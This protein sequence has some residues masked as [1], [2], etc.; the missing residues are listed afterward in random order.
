MPLGLHPKARDALLPYIRNFID[1]AKVLHGTALS[2]SGS[3][4]ELLNAETKLPQSGPIR[5]ALSRYVS[6]HSVLDFIPEAIQT[7]L[8]QL[9]YTEERNELPLIAALEIADVEV[10][11][12]QLLEEFESLPWPYWATINLPRSLADFIT[13]LDQIHELSPQVRLIHDQAEIGKTAA[14]DMSASNSLLTGLGG[15]FG[16]T[17]KY[18]EERKALQLKVKG[19]VP[20]YGGSGTVDDTRSLMRSF[21]GIGVALEIF[22][23]SYSPALPPS[24]QQITFRRFDHEEGI[25][26]SHSLSDAETS[27]IY[28]L[29]VPADF[30]TGSGEVAAIARERLGSVS[31]ILQNPDKHS[32]LLRACEWL[33]NSH[34]GDDPLLSFV[35]AMVVLE[36]LLGNKA[37]SKE[38]GLGTLLANRC[39]YMIGTTTSEREM[40]LRDFAAIYDV[41]SQIVHSGKHRLSRREMEQ[42]QRLRWLGRRVIQEE[43]KLAVAEITRNEAV[44]RSAVVKALMDRSGLP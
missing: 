27:A 5:E 39:A 13:R 15:F 9:T 1:G 19:F 10:F 18:S 20:Q 28:K 25:N 38:V 31:A 29:T 43:I 37:S 33:F 16:K 36:I 41:R 11:S 2:Y 40:I 17:A 34:V 7:R 3:F 35:Q 21:F 6:D 23:F 4:M 22:K 42:L 44:Q 8:K 32:L 30:I 12:G 26:P 14:P 24:R